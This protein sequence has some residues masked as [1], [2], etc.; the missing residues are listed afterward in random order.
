M[1][2]SVKLCGWVGVCLYALLHP[3]YAAGIYDGVWAGT[4]SATVDGFGTESGESWTLIYQDGP[5]TL[6]LA[7]VDFNNL[8]QL[9]ASQ[10]QR[11]GSTWILPQ[12]IDAALF[13][14]DVS[15]TS[16]SAGFPNSTHLSGH[17]NF[18][19]SFEGTHHVG[20]GSFN[21]NKQSCTT[22][23]S[24]DTMIGNLSGGEGSIRCYQLQ[25]PVCAANFRVQTSG[26][27]GDLDLHV[28]Y[29]APNFTYY[30]SNDFSNNETV[31]SVP[32]TG[33][34]YIVLEGFDSYSGAQ[35]QVSYDL[36][37]SDGD[38]VSDCVDACPASPGGEQVDGTGCAS[39]EGDNDSDGVPNG[40]D[41]CPEISNSNQANNDQDELGDV[42]D[43]DDDNDGLS[44][45]DEISQYGTDP[46]RADSDGDRVSD[47][48]EVAAGTDPL[49]NPF[50]STVIINSILL[51]D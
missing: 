15:I 2:I 31:A 11:Q 32:Q 23:N 45:I 28:A 22:L 20:T 10:M 51:N 49:L 6:Y 18:E 33:M 3:V 26:G 12:A 16:I 40:Q 35:L 8:D 27:T 34:W 30:A 43:P 37:D 13:G 42:C 7:R 9:N 19:F 24:P 1:N 14:V 44:D 46:R 5:N 21:F 39:S 48:D 38:G 47:G 29:G 17:Y 50:T 4:E 25:L 41:N 36:P